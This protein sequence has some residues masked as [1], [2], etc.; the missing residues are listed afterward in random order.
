MILLKANTFSCCQ[1]LRHNV[2]T[3]P[4]SKFFYYPFSSLKHFRAFML[5]HEAKIDGPKIFLKQVSFF[6]V[7]PSS[8][9]MI[10]KLYSEQCKS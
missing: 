7:S 6:S 2:F 1:A 10:D 8:D 3:M 4:F 5:S 9:K